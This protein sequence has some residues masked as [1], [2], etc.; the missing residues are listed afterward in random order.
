MELG[1]AMIDEQS[2]TLPP[3][4]SHMHPSEKRGH[5]G[6]RMKT[7]DDLRRERTWLEML[8]RVHRVL[9]FG[10]WQT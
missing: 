4:T 9:T 10:L 3:S 8:G 2:L 5:L 1:I 6:W 7:L